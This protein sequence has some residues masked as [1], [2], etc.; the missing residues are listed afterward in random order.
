MKI[1]VVWRILGDVKYIASI[2]FS[3]QKAQLKMRMLDNDSS[4]GH[5]KVEPFLLEY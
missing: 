5:G 4:E 2:H 1:Y 3:K